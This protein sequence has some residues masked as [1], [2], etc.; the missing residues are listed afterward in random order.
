M[1]YLLLFLLTASSL[2]SQH[3]FNNN[4]LTVSGTTYVPVGSYQNTLEN[5]FFMGRNEGKYLRVRNDYTDGNSYSTGSPRGYWL[6]TGGFANND[7][8]YITREVRCYDEDGWERWDD[9]ENG[10]FVTYSNE[11]DTLKIVRTRNRDLYSVAYK[12][13]MRS[14]TLRLKTGG[15]VESPLT[16]YE[17]AIACTPEHDALLAGLNAVDLAMSRVANRADYTQRLR[18]YESAAQHASFLP[19]VITD[20]NRLAQEIDRYGT[21]ME[22]RWELVSTPTST[23]H[24]QTNVLNSNGHQQNVNTP[25]SATIPANAIYTITTRTPDEN[26]A[27]HITSTSYSISGPS[28]TSTSTFS[29]DFYATSHGT[30]GYINID[31]Y[32]S[33]NRYHVIMESSWQYPQIMRID[34]PVE[35]NGE[36]GGHRRIVYNRLYLRRIGN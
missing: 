3:T 22:G 8:V 9:P 15:G 31:R 10:H 26:E 33:P 18:T 32:G 23:A 4:M 28:L 14:D 27:N 20:V 6:Y 25:I 16:T 29:I 36:F 11:I 35:H 34:I 30:T 1:R 7:Q 12:F 24:L 17:N 13:Y 5:Q 21:P 2:Y 19:S